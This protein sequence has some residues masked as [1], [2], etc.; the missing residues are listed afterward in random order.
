MAR[1]S[2]PLLIL[3]AVACA[4]I[5]LLAVSFNPIAAPTALS[6][7]A[8]LR[9]SSHT[10]NFTDQASK[11]RPSQSTRLS[12]FVGVFTAIK[13]GR[14]RVVR[15]TWFPSSAGDLQRFVP[16]LFDHMSDW[17]ICTSKTSIPG[18]RP[19]LVSDCDLLL[20]NSKIRKHRLPYRRSSAST[21]TLSSLQLRKR[22]IIWC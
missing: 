7:K 9:Y 18:L 12:A 22:M 8:H 19:K 3:L 14:R 16:V 1:N 6:R 15:S 2:T 13:P 17:D 5:L 21:L 10:V 20:A 11:T 4:L